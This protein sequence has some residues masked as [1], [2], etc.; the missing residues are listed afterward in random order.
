MREYRRAVRT[1]HGP[2]RRQALALVPAAG[3]GALAKPGQGVAI[4][5][6]ART[7]LAA[8]GFPAGRSD[9]GHHRRREHA[10]PPAAGARLPVAPKAPHAENDD[11]GVCRAPDG[12]RVRA[13]TRRTYG[14]A[15]SATSRW[16]GGGASTYGCSSSLSVSSSIGVVNTSVAAGSVSCSVSP[17]A[18]SSSTVSAS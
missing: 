13:S 8:D 1:A 4:G 18:R 12:T 14:R 6:T 2:A 10:F 11:T 17:V 3:P 9:P 15:C 7:N 5:W 16:S